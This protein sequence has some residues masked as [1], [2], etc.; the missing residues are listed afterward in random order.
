MRLNLDAFLQGVKR[1]I[2]L[3]FDDADNGNNK[4]E[5]NSQEKYFLLRVDITNYNV[6]ID[7]RNFYDQSINNPVKK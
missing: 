7:G 6:L 3:S 4:I 1:L 2:V 5:R